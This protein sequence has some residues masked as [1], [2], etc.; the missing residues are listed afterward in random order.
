MCRAASCIEPSGNALGCA[1][2]DA[3]GQALGCKCASAVCQQHNGNGKGERLQCRQRVQEVTP[4]RMSAM[5]EGGAYQSI[6]SPT[7][8]RS[9]RQV[10]P[11]V[12]QGVFHIGLFF[13]DGRDV[14]QRFSGG[15]KALS[16]CND[17][18]RQVRR[19]KAAAGRRHIAVGVERLVQHFHAGFLHPG[20][21]G[22]VRAGRDAAQ[23]PQLGR[24]Q[25][26]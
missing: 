10:R 18:R 17:P 2:L 8:P 14:V 25:R 9:T 1:A 5:R 23:Q 16:A 13:A 7:P 4:D 3:V 26:P 12:A 21:G 22:Q 19:S 20:F 15:S 6:G 11:Q 24:Y